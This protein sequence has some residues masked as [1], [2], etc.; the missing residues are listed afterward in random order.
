MSVE[1]VDHKGKKILHIKYAG[2]SDEAMLEQMKNATN[3]L[4]NT[5]SE[6]NLVLTD[7]LDCF[8]NEKFVALAKEQGKISLPFSKKSA[9]VGVTGIKKILLKGVNAISPKSRVP[10]DT[11]EEAKDWLVQL[12]VRSSAQVFSLFY[13]G[14]EMTVFIFLRIL[15]KSSEGKR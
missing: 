10:F 7:M 15:T 4:V 5:K 2:L 14:Y 6:E 11:I 8:L 12:V 13:I 9:I 3:M 1:W